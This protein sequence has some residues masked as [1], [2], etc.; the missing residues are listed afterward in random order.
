MLGEKKS[1]KEDFREIDMQNTYLG[2][3]E[4]FKKILIK[5]YYMYQ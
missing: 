5:F 2:K 3:E 1:K 4:V